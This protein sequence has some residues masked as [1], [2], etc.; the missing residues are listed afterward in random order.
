MNRE[1]KELTDVVI[2]I[3]DSGLGAK[4]ENPYFLYVFDAN[5]KPWPVPVWEMG[6]D[7]IIRYVRQRY[8]NQY[9]QWTADASALT[10][11]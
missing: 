3:I 8:G 4:Y 2:S 7:E 11:H 6:R 10:I 9:A 5:G 1:T